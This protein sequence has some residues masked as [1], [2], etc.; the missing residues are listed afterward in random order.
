M[1]KIFVRDLGFT[2]G[3]EVLKFNSVEDA[4]KHIKEVFD[5][6]NNTD[7]IGEIKDENGQEYGCAWSVKLEKI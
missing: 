5:L 6:D 3:P 2:L 7:W 4:E 1:A